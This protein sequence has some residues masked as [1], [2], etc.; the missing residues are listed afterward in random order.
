MLSFSKF[1]PYIA[2]A[3]CQKVKTNP[4]PF[5]IGIAVSSNLQGAATL[6]G[7]ITA[8]M[9]G[10]ALDMSFLNFFWYKGKPSMFFVVETGAVVV[11]FIL[12][13]LFRK[14]KAEIPKDAMAPL[15]EIDLNTI[16]LL[17]GLFLMNGGITNMGVI[18]KAAELLA[19]AGYE[20]KNSDFCRIGIPFT[21]AAVI[22]AYIMIWLMF[23][24]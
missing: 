6:V 11:A 2:L 23:G 22:P 5:I 19:K 4:V 18:D 16:G 13:I 17:I 7:D 1:R 21:L 3:I 24:V 10:S 20:V 14:E 15:K 9:L 8:I 12:A